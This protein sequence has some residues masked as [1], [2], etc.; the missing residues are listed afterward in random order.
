MGDLNVTKLNNDDS[1]ILRE[2]SE[3]HDADLI[4]YNGEIDEEGA[5][6]LIEI[7]N[8]TIKN[9]V[10]LYLCTYGGG[11]DAAFRI[12]RRLQN[13]YKKFM[14]YIHGY[15]KSAGTLIA[16]GSD[17]IIM[18]DFGELG[19]LDVQV[20]DKEELLQVSSGLNVFQTLTALRDQN[21]EFYKQ[22]LFH[23]ALRIGLSTKSAAT[24]ASNLVIG[25]FAPI[26]SQI[27]PIKIGELDRA[28]KIA[29]KYG[30][31]LI[32]SGRGNI[33][34]SANPDDNQLLRLVVKYPSH[35]FVIDREEAKEIFKN[36]RNENPTEAKYVNFLNREMRLPYRNKVIKKLWP[37]GEV[38][39]QQEIVK[40][41]QFA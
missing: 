7:T 6:K 14:L 10:M 2:I 28:I 16:V 18:S 30:E 13:K 31:I 34:I 4:L 3:L 21:I 11:A 36:V 41:E 33:A 32:K 17:E 39:S 22:C 27:D 37:I 40:D 24:I 23:L 1:S 5:D 38:I 35:S 9:N 20:S 8:S 19:P 26:L 25:F 12:A 15:C 29:I